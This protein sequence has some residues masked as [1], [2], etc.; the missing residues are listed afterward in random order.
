M[1][2]TGYG[3]GYKVK[4]DTVTERANAKVNMKKTHAVK[5]AKERQEFSKPVHQPRRLP[6]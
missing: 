4:M 5:M 1:A 3:V 2:P 6:D